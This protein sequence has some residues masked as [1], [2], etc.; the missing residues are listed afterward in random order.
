MRSELNGQRGGAKKIEVMRGLLNKWG[1]EDRK[2]WEN[3][4]QSLITKGQ[5]YIRQTRTK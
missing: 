5:S 1:P 4:L 2:V 3:N